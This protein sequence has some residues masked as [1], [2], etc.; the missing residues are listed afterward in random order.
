MDTIIP[1]WTSSRFGVTIILFFGWFYIFSIR[2]NI[3]M[4]IVCMVNHSAIGVNDI[5]V[6]SQ[7]NLSNCNWQNTDDSVY[8][9]KV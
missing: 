4:S 2:V 9:R 7:S 1:F 3:N 8:Q 5:N 6:T